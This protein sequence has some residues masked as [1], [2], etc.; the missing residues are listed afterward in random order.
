M[1]TRLLISFILVLTI[2]PAC[3]RK[4]P[5]ADADKALAAQILQDT[6]MNKVEAMALEVIK[7]GFNAG[8]GYGDVWIRDYNTFIDAAMLVMPDEQIQENLLTF[9]RF[10]GPEGDIPD[11]F[12]DINNVPQSE[13]GYYRFSELEP[14]YAAHKNTVETD[15]ESSLVQA[16]WR[17]VNK[18][19]NKAFLQQEVGGITVL[20]RLEWSLQYLLHHR[21][22]SLHGLLW[23][24]TTADWGDV[25]PEH[26][27]GVALD[28]QSHPCL[29]IYDNAFFIIAMNHF[30]SLTDDVETKEYWAEIRN[31]TYRNVRIYLWD[32]QRQK[33][34]PH[35]YLNGSP[36]PEDFDEAV[37]YYHGGT[38]MAIEAGLLSR[39]EIAV[40]NAAMVANVKASGA[41]T[42][43]LT[44]YPPYPEGF[45]QNKGMYPYGYQNGGDWTWFGGRMIQQLA[46]NGFAREAYDELYPMLERIVENNGF[47]EWYTLDGKPSGSGTF[48]G[49]AGVLHRAIKDLRDWASRQVKQ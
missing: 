45:F 44:V 11:G 26:P 48:R 40:A 30:I 42:I 14:R 32:G 39:E 28:E 49:E 47:Y 37:V 38:A 6:L 12:F 20:N 35:V 8:D 25:Q 17:Y 9:F 18:S 33:F 36:F 31:E 4:N 7:G 13:D 5:L 19:G 24:A 29:D 16:V 21:F 1:K 3:G 46:R 2:L 34:I 41:P 10:Q 43:G 27:W 22:D 15:Q 23:G